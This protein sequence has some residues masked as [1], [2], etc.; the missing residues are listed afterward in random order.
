MYGLDKGSLK[1]ARK[2]RNG[3]NLIYTNQYGGNGHGFI[4]S[5]DI[6]LKKHIVL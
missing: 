3:I 5:V 6:E 1:S 2:T 4:S